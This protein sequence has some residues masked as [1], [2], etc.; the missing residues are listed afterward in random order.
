VSEGIEVYKSIVAVQGALAKEGISKDRKNQQ[1]GFA[2][3]GIDDVYA[4][5][6]PLLA[7]NNLCI[8]PRIIGR[9]AEERTSAKGGVLF[10]TAVTAEFDLVSAIDGSTHTVVSY[11][12]AFDSGDKS[13]GKAMS[14]AYKA[15]AFM[16][17]AIPTEGENDPDAQSHE[18]KPREQPPKSSPQGTSDHQSGV[19]LTPDQEKYFPRVKAALDTLHGTDIVAKKSRIKDLTTFTGKDSKVVPGVEDYRKLDGK[20][21]QILCQNL[22]KLAVPK[23]ET[24]LCNECRKPVDSTGTCR[25]LE[26]PDGKPEEDI[27]Y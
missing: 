22:E 6:A 3:R 15:M 11:G 25:N 23:S 20:R 26:C 24:T 2:Y 7:A 12:E 4:A 5:L 27:P 16:T 14:Y 18:I 19:T 10:Y 13:I 8:L 9:L 17:F 1:Q 21:L